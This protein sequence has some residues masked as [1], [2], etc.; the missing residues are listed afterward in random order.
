MDLGPDD[1]RA[2]LRILAEATEELSAEG[3]VPGS[4]P[5][6]CALLR[7]TLPRVSWWKE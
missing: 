6:A 2:L 5:E 1:K 4:Y 3:S 7:D